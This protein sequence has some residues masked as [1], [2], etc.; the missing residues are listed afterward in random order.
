MLGSAE[1][2]GHPLVSAVPGPARAVVPLSPSPNRLLLRQSGVFALQPASYAQST[3][4]RSG[5]PDTAL[6][7]SGLPQPVCTDAGHWIRHEPAPA[8]GARWRMAAPDF[9]Q[10][11]TL[12]WGGH[13]G[14][15]TRFIDAGGRCA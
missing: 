15:H 6:A 4:H 8:T 9:H 5:H 12:V 2:A 3:P 11:A 1:T 14:A 13:P 7:L 10:C